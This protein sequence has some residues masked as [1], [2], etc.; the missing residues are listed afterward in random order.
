M[1]NRLFQPVCEVEMAGIEP[2]SERIVPRMYYERSRFQVFT[3]YGATDKIGTRLA[4][5]V[6]RPSFAQ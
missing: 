1:Q 6:R 4:A 2:A 5:R 3:G